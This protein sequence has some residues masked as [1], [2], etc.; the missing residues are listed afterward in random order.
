MRMRMSQRSRRRSMQ[1]NTC[2][3]M[4][5]RAS[6]R[7]ILLLGALIA[8][9]HLGC[10]TEDAAPQPSAQTPPLAIR[11]APVL[12][13]DLRHALSY[14]GTV[15]AQRE[16]KI[17]ARIPGT[18]RWLADEGSQVAQGKA[19]AVVSADEMSA[20]TARVDAEV[21]RASAERE[22]RC[23]TYERDQR[24]GDDDAIPQSKV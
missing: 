21:R 9:P 20:K 4:R 24:L 12:R 3:S 16:V 1:A 17:L 8:L 5:L 15:H 2:L 13:R 18:V 14:I 6:I 22:L 11:V 19:L 7:R 23:T 10:S